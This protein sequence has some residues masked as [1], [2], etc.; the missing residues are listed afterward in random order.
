VIPERYFGKNILQMVGHTFNLKKRKG[1][2]RKR[3]SSQVTDAGLFCFLMQCQRRGNSD[4]PLEFIHLKKC[5]THY[6]LLI[7]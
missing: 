2:R 6:L 5:D 7:K 3:K 4:F 1:G